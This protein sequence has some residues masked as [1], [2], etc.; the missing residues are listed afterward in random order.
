MASKNKK[1]K[2]KNSNC[3]SGMLKNSSVKLKRIAFF[4]PSTRK[5]NNKNK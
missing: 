3:V 2:L 1:R 4:T 5:K